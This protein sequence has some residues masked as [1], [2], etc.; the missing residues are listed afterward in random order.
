[1]K[2]QL[3]IFDFQEHPLS[4]AQLEMEVKE[5]KEQINNLRRG[6]FR[7]Y[8]EMEEE[9]L[10]IREEIRAMRGEFDHAS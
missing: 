10:A 9:L 1:M 8:A 4:P 3:S 6:L 2:R 5:T 7:R